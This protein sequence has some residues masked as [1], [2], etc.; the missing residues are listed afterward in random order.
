LFK[1]NLSIPEILAL[2]DSL[3]VST[4]NP[5][6]AETVR[7]LRIGLST[8]VDQ[9]LVIEKVKVKKASIISCIQYL[10]FWKK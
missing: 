10:P 5:N 1:T 4:L 7:L 6:R 3:R 8:L 2:V 9:V